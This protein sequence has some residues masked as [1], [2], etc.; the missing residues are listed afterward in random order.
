MGFFKCCKGCD[1]RNVGCHGTYP[2]YIAEK[3]AYDAR[4]AEQRKR[5]GIADGLNAQ[6]F[7]AVRRATKRMDTNPRKGTKNG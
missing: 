7:D 5:K 1:S 2:S 3:M 6:K 4:A